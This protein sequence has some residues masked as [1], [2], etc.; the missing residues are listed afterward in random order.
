M[1]YDTHLQGDHNN[2]GVNAPPWSIRVAVS[3]PEGP[4]SDPYRG[5]DDF[6]ELRHDYA[7]KDTIIGA[8]NAPFPR[9]VLVESFDEVFNTPL[10]YNYNITFEREV[11]T[12]WMA[13]AGYVGSTATT[14]RA[15]ITLNPAIYTPGGPTGNPQARRRFPEFGEINHFVQDRSSQHYSMQLSLN[16]R[17]AAGFT[18]RA[19]YTLADLQGTIGGPELAPYFHPDLDEIVDTLRYGRLA[20]MRRHRFVTSWVYDIP[21]PQE[22]VAGA[23]VGGWQVTGIYQWQSGQPITIESGRDNAG[24]GLGSNRAIKTGQPFEPPAGSDETVWFNRAAFAVNPNG[25]FGETLRG[26][27]FGPSRQ[28]VDLGLFKNFRFTTDMNVQFRAEFFNLLNTVNFNNPGTYVSSA[29]TFGRINSAQDPR[30]MQFGLKF[31]F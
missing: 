31:V 29:S 7:D 2:G 15:D 1:F 24:W 12:G 20:D 5:R 18:V 27:Y 23:V 9:P 28:T 17:Y 21:G 11:A 14:G 8:T 6:N 22:G 3:E 10:T 26:E 19:N 13:R 25:T 16:R 30:I 4:F